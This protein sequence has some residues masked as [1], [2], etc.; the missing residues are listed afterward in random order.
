[1]KE[2]PSTPPEHPS[3]LPDELTQEEKRW[4]LT[5]ARTTITNVCKG[6]PAPRP[7]NP[8]QKTTLP[9]ASFVT[10]TKNGTLRGC[11]GTLH[12][13]R[14]L[15]EDVAANAAAAATL[16][17]RFPPVTPEELDDVTIEISLLTTPQ[18]LA[19][20]SPDELLSIL[21]KEK[22]GVILSDKGRSATFLPQVWEQLPQPEAFLAHLCLK[23]GLP[24]DD[25]RTSK[26]VHV[27]TYHVQKWGEH[28]S[29]IRHQQQRRGTTSRHDRGSR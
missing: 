6:E 20:S 19:F 16:D 18:P 22:P 17:P 26:T 13:Y 4:L 23:A 21:E 8:P 9:G 27:K 2:K 7:S 1:M 25:W 11:I 10:L 3:A 12:P 5:L 15:F 14:P 24:P 28:P 29:F